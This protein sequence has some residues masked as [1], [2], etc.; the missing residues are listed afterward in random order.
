VPVAYSVETCRALARA[1]DQAQVLRPM[2][3]GRYD[4]GTELALEVTGVAPRRR[5]RV[6]LRL[7][8]FVGGGFAGQV[9]RVRVLSAEGEHIDGLEV[10]ARC[11]VKILLPPSAAKR[12]FREALFRLGFQG[13]FA[14]Q[15]NP[16]AARAGAIWQ[17]LI[18]R[19][20][21]IHLGSERAVVD[22][23]ATFFDPG[24]GS[25]GEI[26]EW[27]DGRDW[28]FEADDRLDDRKRWL[29]GK[30][31]PPERLGSAEYRAKREFMQRL[32]ALL[33]AMGAGELARQYEWWTAKSQPNVLKRR[34]DEADPA[35]GLTAVDFRAGLALLPFLPMSPADVKLI[36]KGIARGSLV[37]FDRGDMGKL[38]RFVDAHA[39]D[40]ADLGDALD[41]L[42]VLEREYR[43]SLPDVTHHHVR[44]LYSGRL[45]SGILDGMVTGWRSRGIADDRAADRLRAGRFRTIL[46]A[47]LGLAPLAGLAGAA[48]VLIW[49]LAAG[50]L[51]WSLAGL[52]AGAGIGAALIARLGR[53]LWGRADLRRHYGRMLASPGYFRRALRARAAEM[54]T[55]WHRG[56]RVSAERAMKLLHSPVRIFAHTVLVAWMPGKLH[57]FLTDRRFAWSAVKQIVARPV[58]LYFN[59]ALREQWLR[60]MVAEGRANGMLTDEE[61]D[62]ITARIREPFIQKYLKSLAV[63]V[64]TLPITQI[65]SVAVAITYVLQHPELSWSEAT[66]RAGLILGA[67]QVTPISPGSLVRGLYVVGLVLRERNF[68]DYNI[69]VF[70]GF[71]KYIGYLAFP[72]Q[73]AYRYPAL[74]RFMAGRWATGAAHVVPVFG[75]RGALLEHGVFDAFYNRLLTLR[76]QFGE[77][78]EARRGQRLRLWHL[79]L[80]VLGGLGA[81]VLIEVV[82]SLSCARVPA[83]V[84]MWWLAVWPPLLAGAAGAA[85]GGGAAV[86][87]RILMGLAVGV[88][89]AIV[90]GIANTTLGVLA[91]AGRARP[92]GAGVVEAGR[93]LWPFLVGSLWRLFLLPILSTLGA[94]L[95]ETK[96]PPPKRSPVPSG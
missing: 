67:F 2:R 74:A 51:S 9:Y 35:A 85:W 24:L 88:A 48:G 6:R 31:L 65:V 61:A 4:P 91:A 8:E 54:L 94:F 92:E 82:F 22:V 30:S 25:C 76:R 59:P 68:K 64:C 44:L 16:A 95:A 29:R 73:M 10:D 66:I 34:G 13:A 1:F 7:E 58:R 63:H 43:E 15:V 71:F 14:P 28:R 96:L 81:F 32:T 45:W 49:F 50:K 52:A 39:A 19:G 77:K 72:V 90:Y 38:Q 53:R 55:D 47:L 12:R 3:I 60:E 37:Q 17:K 18:R 62:H 57:R 21:R 5:A 33:H 70:L 26:S 27:V 20:A 42:K 86:N 23:L 11:A 79:P 87:K 46:F 36:L 56:G 80:C 89:M 75:E 69:A 84:A 93:L 40:F 78:D 41:E 83:P